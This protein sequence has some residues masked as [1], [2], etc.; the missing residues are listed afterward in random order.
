MGNLTGAI[1]KPSIALAQRTTGAAVVNGNAISTVGVDEFKHFI[2]ATA[3]AAGT[4]GIQ[5]VQFADDSS[6]TVNVDTYTSDNYLNK[7]D[8]DS[9]TSAIAQT[10]LS[11]VGGSCLAHKNLSKNGQQFMRV[12]LV[13]SAGSP[14]VTAK[15][16]TLVNYLDKPQVQA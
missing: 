14:D 8:R 7:N 1:L 6:F 11:A 13:A 2:A 10:V 3:R 16:D 12:R 4:N 5:D 9:A 15:V